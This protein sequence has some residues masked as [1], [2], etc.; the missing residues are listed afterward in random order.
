[1]HEVRK[2]VHSLYGPRDHEADN[3]VRSRIQADHERHRSN[4]VQK[5][6]TQSTAKWTWDTFC[7]HDH[8]ICKLASI[9]KRPDSHVSDETNTC[10]RLTKSWTKPDENGRHRANNHDLAL[11]YAS[12]SILH[13]ISFCLCVY[14]VAERT[15]QSESELLWTKIRT[16]MLVKYINLLV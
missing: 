3:P 16:S 10:K 8:P 5:G 6:Q 9:Y 15:A 7:S 4:H 1:M 12:R 14:T 2:G 13:I 11:L